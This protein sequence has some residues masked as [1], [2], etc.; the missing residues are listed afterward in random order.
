MNSCEK[1][2]KIRFGCFSIQFLIVC[3]PNSGE[4]FVYC[5]FTQY[6]GKQLLKLPYKTSW[7]DMFKLVLKHRSCEC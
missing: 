1:F 4:R 5:G 6:M 2:L 3:N 7:L